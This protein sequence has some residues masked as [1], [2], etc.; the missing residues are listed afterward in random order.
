MHVAGHP[1]KIASSTACCQHQHFPNP[2]NTQKLLHG[3][4]LCRLLSAETF[5]PFPPLSLSCRTF[6]PNRITAS[7]VRRKEGRKGNSGLIPPASSFFR[8]LLSFLL[9]RKVL[10]RRPAAAR[11]S[12]A[13]QALIHFSHPLD[14]AVGR[15]VGRSAQKAKQ[16]GGRV[17]RKR[18]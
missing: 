11:Y 2:N 4:V 8:F 1:I 5:R 7:S 14:L 9:G 16:L 18:L 10:L 3:W 15:S 17:N 13:Y 6:L 12:L